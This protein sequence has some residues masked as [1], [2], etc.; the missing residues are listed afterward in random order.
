MDFVEAVISIDVRVPRRSAFK[1]VQFILIE[2]M[3]WPLSISQ[4]SWRIATNCFLGTFRVR[5]TQQEVFHRRS[6]ILVRYCR[7]ES[8]AC[9]F[10]AP[11]KCVNGTAARRSIFYLAPGHCCDTAPNRFDLYKWQMMQNEA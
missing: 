11:K 3:K 7:F 2:S 1:T 10:C 9:G 8:L 5:H 6:S 4:A